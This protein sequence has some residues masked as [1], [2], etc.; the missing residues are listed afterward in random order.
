MTAITESPAGASQTVILAT[1]SNH[2]PTSS[3]I[4]SLAPELLLNIFK[5]ASS[6]PYVVNKLD[7]PPWVLTFVNKKWRAVAQSCSS[8]WSNFI[9][10]VSPDN[11]F[12][13]RLL[14]L[15]ISRTSGHPLNVYWK[16]QGEI[17]DVSDPSSRFLTVFQTFLHTSPRWRSVT[18]EFHSSFLNFFIPLSYHLDTL[19]EMRIILSDNYARDIQSDPLYYEIDGTNLSVMLCSALR[20]Q[21][22]TQ[23]GGPVFFPVFE[24]LTEYS[25]Q[26]DI[27]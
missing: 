13:P 7:S 14:E 21:H 3:P 22:F 10:D 5:E 15:A 12:D 18:Y 20:L 25:L 4:E 1:D 23:W 24:H 27:T 26:Y 9:V 6:S 19:E 11:S 8:L 16:S 2:S 17:Q